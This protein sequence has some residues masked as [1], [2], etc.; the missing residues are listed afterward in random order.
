MNFAFAQLDRL[1]EVDR[2][3]CFARCFLSILRRGRAGL[4]WRKF[5]G[6]AIALADKI[7]VKGP[8]FFEVNFSIRSVLPRV[9][10]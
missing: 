4:A 1:G 6:D 3:L 10:S 8:P 9:T 7:G 5:P 2:R